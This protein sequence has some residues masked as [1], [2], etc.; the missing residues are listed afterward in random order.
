[1]CLQRQ[2]GE[3]RLCL[4]GEHGDGGRFNAEARLARLPL[5]LLNPWLGDQLSLAGEINLDSRFS[6]TLAAAN[7]EWTLSADHTRLTVR[8]VGQDHVFDLDTARL[9]GTLQQGSLASQLALVVAGHGSLDAELNTRL[10]AAAPVDGRLR[11]D[12][13]KLDDFAALIPQIGELN[14]A[15]RGELNL[16][17]TQDAPRLSGQIDLTG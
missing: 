8:D 4:G 12:I 13:P 15:V 14:G 6:G 11:L 9:D 17:G 1:L 3:G 10:S 5:T 2:S 7:G 16:S